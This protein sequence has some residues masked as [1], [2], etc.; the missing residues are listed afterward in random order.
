[1]CLVLTLALIAC[2]G[3]CH[4]GTSSISSVFQENPLVTYVHL[5]TTV[6]RT[7]PILPPTPVQW[8]TIAPL[9]P[10]TLLSIPAHQELTTLTS[11]VLT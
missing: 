11:Q 10:P 7:L 9:V 1:M 8:V 3:T 5:D 2:Y 4:Q 6:N